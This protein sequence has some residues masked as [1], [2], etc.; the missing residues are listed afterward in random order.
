MLATEIIARYKKPNAPYTPDFF[1][2]EDGTFVWN[3]SLVL[4]HYVCQKYGALKG[5]RVLELGSGLG[6]A[7]FGLARYQ[8]CTRQPRSVEIP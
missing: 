3:A 4:Q 7:A 6:H 2:F 8:T 5:K 1:E